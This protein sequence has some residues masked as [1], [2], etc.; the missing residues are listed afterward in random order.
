[1]SNEEYIKQLEGLVC[2][3]ASCY[4][5]NQ[6]EFQGKHFKTCSIDNPERRELTN[7][8]LD[9]L[10]RFV[11]IQGTRN[12]LAVKNLAQLNIKPTVSISIIEDKILKNNKDV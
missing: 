4:D 1:M 5:G 2:F 11:Q 9:E 8:E 7:S 10:S 6:E 3:L 12:I